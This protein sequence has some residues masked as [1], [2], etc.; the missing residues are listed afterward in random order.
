MNKQFKLCKAAHLLDI[1]Y[2]T[3]KTVMR[4]YRTENKIFRKGVEE[5]KDLK[6]ILQKLQKNSLRKKNKFFVTKKN[7][8][9]KNDFLKI[10]E[11]CKF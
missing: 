11:K 6:M 7:D 2:S 1:K 5:E 8:K 3:A 9:L 10:T 4:L